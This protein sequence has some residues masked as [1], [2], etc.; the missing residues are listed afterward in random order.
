MVPTLKMLGRVKFRAERVRAY[1]LW[2]QALMVLDLWLTAHGLSWWL[3]LA[4]GVP[5]FFVIYW[6]DRRWVYPGESE[7]SWRDNP[8]WQK[9][10]RKMNEPN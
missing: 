9:L 10:M 5:V 2:A 1:A 3:A 8:E 6:I 4:V 7:I